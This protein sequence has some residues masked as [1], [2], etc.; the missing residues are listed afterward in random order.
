MP[1]IPVA[2]LALP[3]SRNQP[4]AIP[5]NPGGG[6]GKAPPAPACNIGL[7]CPSAAYDEVIESIT[8]CAFSCPIS[9][10]K[11]VS[12]TFHFVGVRVR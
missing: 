3:T 2:M 10:F 7:A 6:G 1:G 4:C 12:A 8:D 5:G 9:A 11:S